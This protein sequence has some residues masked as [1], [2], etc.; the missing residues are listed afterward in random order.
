MG[1]ARDEAEK[2]ERVTAQQLGDVAN[3]LSGTLMRRCSFVNVVICFCLLKFF[4]P[5]RPG[6]VGAADG[7][8][9]Q[10]FPE[11]LDNALMALEDASSQTKSL[12]SKAKDALTCLHGSVLPKGQPP[13]S[14]GELTDLFSPGA[15]AIGDFRREH[16]VRGSQ[17]TLLMLLG[18]GFEG[19]FD[20]WPPSSLDEL[21]DL[22]GP[23]ASTHGDFRREHTV[24]GSQTTL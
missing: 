9:G 5:C 1:A 10:T 14:L 16:T 23:D 12:L 24:R 17:T 2:R 7:S 3:S 18:N 6:Y 4:C 19:D 11:D 22:F 13:S 21:V 8:G 20:S 15:S